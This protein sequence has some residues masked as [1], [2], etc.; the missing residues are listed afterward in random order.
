MNTL[1]QR[2]SFYKKASDSKSQYKPKL[3]VILKGIKNGIWRDVI[4]AYRDEEDEDK[5]KNLK[6]N[7]P[8]PTFAGTFSYRSMKNLIT[9]TGIIV[10]DVDIKSENVIM[11]LKEKLRG[12]KYVMCYF[13]SPSKGLKVM[14]VMDCQ[15]SEHKDHG[16]PAIKT[17]F[18]DSYGID[19]DIKCKDIGRLCF[20]SHDPELYL[21]EKFEPF[22]VEIIEE[23]PIPVKKYKESDHF[24]ENHNL[25]YIIKTCIS[26]TED[27]GVHF[28]ANQS[29]NEFI[30]R[31]A[32]KLN[33]C[34]VD[35]YTAIDRLNSMY[36]SK[37]FT[38][39]E[40]ITTVGGA[41]KRNKSEFGTK[42]VYSK[43]R[44]QS[45]LFS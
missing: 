2:V 30:H 26:W 9:Y 7:L 32:C 13:E 44:K 39:K 34:G 6:S 38:H 23:E 15:A 20:V 11:R 4:S 27:D 12:D 28:V 17:H 18:E 33:R 1:D 31:L 25:D 29:R 36:S 21:N 37:S 8:C 5:K 22:H 43:N 45:N 3:G 41:Y 35:E 14:Y 42:K 24:S 10:V 19:V 16:F 40:I